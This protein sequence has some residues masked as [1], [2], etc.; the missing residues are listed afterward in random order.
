MKKPRKNCGFEYIGRFLRR[1]LVERK[2]VE[3][4]AVSASE[5]DVRGL[6]EAVR[7]SKIEVKRPSSSAK[8]QPERHAARRAHIFLPFERSKCERGGERSL[9]EAETERVRTRPRLRTF[10]WTRVL[11]SISIDNGVLLALQFGSICRSFGS[12]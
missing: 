6:P 3:K 1:A 9:G 8:T 12:A 5:I 10:E 7:A 11:L 2:N 4:T